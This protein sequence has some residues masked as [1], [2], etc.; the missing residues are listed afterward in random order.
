MESCVMLVLFLCDQTS[1]VFSKNVNKEIVIIIT[2]SKY[3]LKI[4]ENGTFAILFKLRQVS[5]CFRRSINEHIL[6]TV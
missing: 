5:D 3:G 4:P 1:P 6:R 2:S